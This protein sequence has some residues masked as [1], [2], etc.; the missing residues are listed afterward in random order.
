MRY[1]KGHK[2]E[3][4]RRILNIAAKLFLK[5]GID[6]VGIATIMK[7]AGLTNGGFYAH[8]KSKDALVAEM[9][10]E[11]LEQKE[12]EY[13]SN[14][15]DPLVYIKFYLSP[16]HR[17]RIEC[18]CPI[19]ALLSELVHHS[20]ATRK[21]LTKWSMRTVERIAT[22][23]N[24]SEEERNKKA[25]SIMAILFGSLQMARAVTDQEL[26]DRIL[27]GAYETAV[28]LITGVSEA[29]QSAT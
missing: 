2:D 29:Q 19:S 11:I 7:E 9:L 24:G 23:L 5:H 28:K 25:L 21:V 26:S 22:Q 6:G 27:S 16:H 4:H 17:D 13:L 14:N 10:D 20:K 3:T 12:T 8:F 18:G 1:D 15:T